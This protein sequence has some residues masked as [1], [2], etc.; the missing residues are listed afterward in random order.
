MPKALLGVTFFTVRESANFLGKSEN[1]VRKD[2]RKARLV[3]KKQGKSWFI[4]ESELN[5]FVTRVGIF[6]RR[7]KLQD[8]AFR[9][10]V[11]FDSFLDKADISQAGHDQALKGL[12]CP[13]TG[14]KRINQEALKLKRMFDDFLKKGDISQGYYNQAIERLSDFL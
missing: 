13:S 2:L 9:I 14:R 3:G 8:K 1:A 11:T 12:L 6:R 7:H 4:P 5:A 10:I